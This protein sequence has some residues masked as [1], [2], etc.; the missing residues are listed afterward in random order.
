M[1]E[2]L[3]LYVNAHTKA[4]LISKCYLIILYVCIYSDYNENIIISGY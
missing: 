4:F 2:L 1:I 3:L